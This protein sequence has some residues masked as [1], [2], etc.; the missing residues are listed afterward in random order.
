MKRCS[1]LLFEIPKRKI[2]IIVTTLLRLVIIRTIT[3]KRRG[4]RSRRKRRMNN[5][6]NKNRMMN[7]N[8]PD[9]RTARKTRI[10]E[11]EISCIQF[12]PIPSRLLSTFTQ[13]SE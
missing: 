7:I 6:K 5:S 1:L 12:A 9:M 10:A 13:L 11:D 8:N 4:R 3:R 2:I